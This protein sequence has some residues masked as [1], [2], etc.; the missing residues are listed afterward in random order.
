MAEYAERTGRPM[1]AVIRA[2]I[3]EYLARHP[4]V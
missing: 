4:A 3:D 2:A 1:S